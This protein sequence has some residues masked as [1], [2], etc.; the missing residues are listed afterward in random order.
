[1]DERNLLP[2]S[3]RSGVNFNVYPQCSWTEDHVASL[4]DFCTVK[5]FYKEIIDA[6]TTLQI[7]K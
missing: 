3:I 1:M 7:Q 6:I 5:R 4:K 2:A